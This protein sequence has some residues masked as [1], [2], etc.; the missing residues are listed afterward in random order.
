VALGSLALLHA[1]TPNVREKISLDGAWQFQ[2]DKENLGEAQQWYRDPGKLSSQISVPGCWQ[3]QGFGDPLGVLRHHYEGVAWYAKRITVPLEW[4]RMRVYLNVG[5]A[6]TYTKVYVNGLPAGTHEGFSTPFRLD[7]TALVKHGESNLLVLRVSNVRDPLRP[8]RCTLMERDT[9]EPTGALNFAAQWGGL[10]R[11]VWLEARE[12]AAIEGVAI[13]TDI[14]K[15]LARLSVKVRNDSSAPL[16]GA[17]L[18]VRI[19]PRGGPEQARGVE[20]L[21]LGAGSESDVTVRVAVPQ[22]RLWSPDSP[23]LYEA[24]VALRLGG[25]LLDEQRETFGFREVKASGSWLLLNGKPVYLRGYGDDSAEV[26]TGAPPPDR[27]TYVRRMRIAKQFGF[28]AVRFHS[29]TPTA[30]C[31]EAADETGLLVL[32]ELP[33]VYQEYLL[34]HKDL[35]RNELVRIIETHRNHPSWFLFTLGNEF[36][37]HRILDRRGKEVFLETVREFVALAKSIDP[38]LLVSSNTGYLVPPMDVAIP[39]R[40]FSREAPNLKHEYGGYH[41]T[42][43]DPSLI[44]KYT[45]V[46]DPLWLKREKEWIDAAA[47]AEYPRYLQNSWRLH[48]TAVKAYLEKLRTMPE[49]TGYFYWLINDYPGG[50]AEGPAWN[51]G[52]LNQFFEPKAITPEEGRQLNSAVMPLIS[53]PIYSRT[54]WAEDGKTLDALI[55]NYGESAIENAKLDWELSGGGQRLASGGWTLPALPLG[56]ITRAGQIRIGKLPLTEASELELAVNLSANSLRSGNRWKLWAFPRAGLLNR[57]GL[58]VVNLIRSA[59]LRRFFPFIQDAGAKD[60]AGGVLIAPDFR[61]RVVEFLRAGGRVL[62]LAE[63]GRFGGRISYFPGTGGALGVSL[64]KDHA[65]LAGFPHD[66]FPDLQFF[67]LIEGGTELALS[68]NLKPLVGGVR[69]TRGSPANVLSRVSLVSEAR[70]GPGRLLLTTLNLRSNLDEAFP[71]AVYLLDRLLRYVTGPEFRPAVELTAEQIDE[72]RV[73]YT[74]MIH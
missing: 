13:T 41:A 7:L 61:P 71:E 15:P 6:F 47:D 65:L 70:V 74:E 46:F 44:P 36:G 17:Q 55:S 56:A 42:L 45:G 19:A 28:N 33:V 25:R 52:W 59:S 53:A 40:G 63:P 72:M 54:L 57:S 3:A 21:S 62:V 4:R 68:R 43:P 31:F 5:G 30:E 20:T 8:M 69:M 18:E 51:W 2:L 23:S 66:G 37:L 49:F 35:L 60:P 67:N 14:R 29:T 12:P 50:T 38:E 73:P 34:P 26:L 32:A 1:Q 22:A 24:A 27:E 64:P 48:A 58:P 16:T 9:S 39:Y 10:Y 11:S